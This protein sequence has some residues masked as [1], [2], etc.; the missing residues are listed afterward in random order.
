MRSRHDRLLDMAE[1]R[2]SLGVELGVIHRH[3]E[4]DELDGST[5]TLDGRSLVD[6]S[7]CSYLGL[8]HDPRLKAGAIDAIGRYGTSYSSSPDRKSTRLNSS[9]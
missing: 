7:T 2:I 3:L 5:I 4:D 9:H 1:R 6:F 8:N